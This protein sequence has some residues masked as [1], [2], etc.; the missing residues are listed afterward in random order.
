MK[1]MSKVKEVMREYD[2]VEIAKNAS[3]RCEMVETFL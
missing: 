1:E 3:R 2:E